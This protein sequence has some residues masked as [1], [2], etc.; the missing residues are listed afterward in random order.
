MALFNHGSNYDE[1]IHSYANDLIVYNLLFAFTVASGRNSHSLAEKFAKSKLAAV[2]HLLRNWIDGQ[3]S[4]PQKKL[5]LF[6]AQI[7]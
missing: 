4:V 6:K 1:Y 3:L 2:A 5:R 7:S